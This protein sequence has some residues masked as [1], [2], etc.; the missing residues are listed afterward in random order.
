MMT[1]ESNAQPYQTSPIRRHRRTKAEIEEIKAKLL[2]IV[3][4]DEPMTV[5]QVFYRAVV[6]GLVEKTENEYTNT[7]AR[8]LLE[9]RRARDMPYSWITDA[10]R[11]MHKGDS[12]DGLEDFIES[13][14]RAYRR[15]LWAESETYV[16]IWCE[17][18][19]LAGVLYDVTYEFDVPLMVSKGFASESYLY[20]AAD[21]ITDRLLNGRREAI[22]YFFGDHDPS[23]LKISKSIEEGIRRLAGE[24]WDRS[25]RLGEDHLRFHRTAVTPAQ[26]QRWSLPTRPTKLEGNRHAKDWDAEQGSVELDAIPPKQLRDL[27]RMRIGNHVDQRKLAA[28]R[29]IEAEEREQLKLFGQ[30]LGGAP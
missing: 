30:S 27:V 7:V 11:W 28:L 22:I 26:I 1:K 24:M 15:D 2:A 9:M 10:T 8:L 21:T 29:Q 3:E 14:Q 25:D 20:S 19:A 5:R 4:E 18:E 6:A 16:E 23:G 12:Y 17:K 13:H